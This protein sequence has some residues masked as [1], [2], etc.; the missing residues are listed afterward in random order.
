MFMAD[1]APVKTEK[2]IVSIRLGSDVLEKLDR[3]AGET[4]ISRN[5]LVNQ[6]IEF[7]LANFKKS[8]Q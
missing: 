1:F 7:A 6:C 4:D 8:Q 5:E 3:I 2:I